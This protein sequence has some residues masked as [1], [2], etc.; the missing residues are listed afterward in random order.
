MLRRLRGSERGLAAFASLAMALALG[1]AGEGCSSDDATEAPPTT[2][3]GMDRTITEI[4]DS[5]DAGKDPSDGGGASAKFSQTEVTFPSTACGGAGTALLSVSN[6]GGGSLA[7]SVTATGGAF[8]VNPTS[9]T[10]KPGKTGTLTITVAVPSSA[11]AGV[12]VLGSLNFFTNDPSKSHLTIPLSATPLGATLAFQAGGATSFAFPDT[13][14]GSPESLTLTLVNVGNAPATFSLGT[15]TDSHFVLGGSASGVNIALSPGATSPATATFTPSSVVSATATST[16][17]ATGTICGTSVQAIELTGQGA[18]GQVAGWP[19]S[20]D[21][22]PVACGGA[23]PATQDFLLTNP[24]AIDAHVTAVTVTGA[25]GFSTTATAG[26]TI[27]AGGQLSVGIVAPGVPLNAPVT[28]IAAT[29]AMLTD[30]DP[31]GASPHSITLTEEPSGAILAFDTSATPNFGSFGSIQL[32]A[33]ASQPFNITNT[34]NAP[35]QVTLLATLVGSGSSPFSVGTPVFSTSGVQSDLLTFTPLVADAVTGSLTM[36][37]TGAI[38]GPLPAPLPLSGSGRGGFPTVTPPSLQFTASCGGAAPQAQSFIVRNDGTADLTWWMTLPTGPGAAQYT[39]SSNP[40]SGTTLIPGAF[41]TVIVSAAAIP[42]PVPNASPSAFAAAITVTTDVPN[43]PG[44][45]VS[46]GEPPLGDQLSIS[47][48]SNTS[49]LRFGQVPIDTVLSQTF[50][51]TNSANPGSPAANLS[52]VLGGSGASGYSTPAPMGNVAAGASATGSITFAPTIDIPYPATVGIHTSDSLCTPLPTPLALSGTGTQGVVSLSA[53][54]LAFGTNPSDPNGLVN[55]GATGLA[56][57]LTVSN[58]GNQAFNITGLTLLQGASSP[59]VLSGSGA[60]LPATV[61][62]GGSV[63][64][65]VT[66][67]PIPQNVADPNNPVPFSDTLTVTTDAALDTPHALDLF[68][69]ARGAV[70]ASTALTTTWPFGTISFGSIGTF[71]NSI[72]NTGNA[73]VSVALMGL[74]QPNIFG[75]ENNPTTASGSAVTPLVGQFTPPSGDG[76][77]SDTGTL[78]VTATE[79]LC[80]PLPSQWTTPTIQ[81]S[82]AS[83]SQPALSASGNLIFPATDCGSPA[84]SGQAITLTN[85]TDVPYPFSARFG[86][87]KYYTLFTSA[88]GGGPS[89]SLP[90]NGTASIVVTPTTINPGPG[91][92]PGS[93]PYADS[94]LVTVTTVP[95]S[96]FTFPISWALNGAVFSLPEGAGTHTDGQGRVFYPAD[97]TSGFLLP[98]ANSGTATASVDF[99]IAPFGAFTLSPAPPIQVIPGIGAAPE[100]VSSGSSPS[101]PSVTVG[102]ATFIYSGAVCQPFP[103]PSVTVESCIGSF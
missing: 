8:S 34:G 99:A 4:Q 80:Q 68:M 60:I 16:V 40:A 35:A 48:A 91:V 75:L 36:T 89:G 23:A 10:V 101:C 78:V 42:T 84:P 9:L 93:A 2:D 13:A 51:V 79:A 3:G 1:S 63:S 65:T 5:T 96:Q 94:L 73:A 37:A 67:L 47:T 85:L 32:L 38:C 39:A 71:S 102:T 25:P 53:S 49:P 17:T 28:P 11:T 18:T 74:S 44:H 72:Q 70:I 12:P 77:W 24:S 19:S 64:F 55:C 6:E 31:P 43:D 66:P 15:P 87:G 82:G 88:A 58:L 29:V 54:T 52:F 76:S 33:S 81:L 92:V 20:I 46:L 50:T 7:L 45:V 83:N 56:K 41:A 97:S 86:S 61:P 90:A 59:F 95:P 22:G 27:P 98:L 21:F 57:N 14:V 100:L 30:A 103:F 26:D 69:Q 62:I